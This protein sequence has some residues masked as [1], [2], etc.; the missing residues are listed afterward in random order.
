MKLR[1]GLAEKSQT[2]RGCYLQDGNHLEEGG[3][4]LKHRGKSPCP[5]TWNL[6]C[7]NNDSGSDEGSHKPRC[8]ENR[9]HD[10]SFLGVGKFS[11]HGRSRNKTEDNTETQNHSSHD[12]HTN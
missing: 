1:G 6:A 3:A 10:W 4:A 2:L 12:V 9:C 5:F 11:Q 7:S 8:V